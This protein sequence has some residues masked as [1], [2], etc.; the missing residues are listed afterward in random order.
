MKI[1]RI[2]FEVTFRCNSHCR[3]CQVEEY[4]RHLTPPVIDAELAAE[5]VKKIAGV[6]QPGSVMT[7]G[8]EPLLYVDVV[9]AIHQAAMQCGIPYRQIITN[10]GLPRLKAQSNNVARRLATSGV[11]EIAISVD[12]F[13]QEYVPLEVVERNVLAY[14]DAG[15]SDLQWNA[16]WVTSAEDDNP[17]D[18]QTRT[19][20][21]KLSYLPVRTGA[22]NILQPAGNAQKWLK[23]YLPAKKPFPPGACEDVPYANRLDEI[24]S[25][26][27]SSDGGIC[28]CTDWKIG[29]SKEEDILGILDGYDPSAIPEAKA[30]LDGGME[31]LAE[32]ARSEGVE[33]DSQGFYSICDMCLHLRRSIQLASSQSITREKM[34]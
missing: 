28:I 27:I 12:A 20:L 16:C 33:L 4:K 19:I 14:L 11:N 9:C 5:I 6:Y 23:D 8:G 30:I 31:G 17:Y 32:L 24:D 10:A 34:R 1:N 7:F 25:I 21:Q 13:H 2:E 22:G 18:Q 3:H 29:N 15:I 26:S